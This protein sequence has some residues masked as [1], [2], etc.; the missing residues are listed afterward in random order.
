MA[1]KTVTD[2]SFQNDVINASGPVLVDFFAEWC[3]PCK[4][5]APV[6]DDVAK[7]LSDRVVI[8]KFNIDENPELPASLGIRSVPTFYLYKDGVKIDEQIGIGKIPNKVR[9]KAWLQEHIS[10]T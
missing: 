8:A 1:T 3:P 4:V 10:L 2:D 6:L 5:I 9:L 7:E